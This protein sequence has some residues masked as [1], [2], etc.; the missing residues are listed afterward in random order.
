MATTPQDRLAK[1]FAGQPLPTTTPSGDSHFSEIELQEKRS[2]DQQQPRWQL[3]STAEYPRQV[4]RSAKPQPTSE[5]LTSSDDDDD[6]VSSFSKKPSMKAP[7][8]QSSQSKRC[9]IPEPNALG[10]PKD[11]PHEGKQTSM[12]LSQDASI[13]LHNGKERDIQSS[14]SAP[15]PLTGRF[16]QFILASKFPYKYMKD[17]NDRVSRHFFAN[18]KFYSRNWDL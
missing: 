9:V 8:E 10:Y 11:V 13:K 3:P 7:S 2:K 14:N 1:L 5:L 17:A 4:T 16:C 18:N 15:S 6:Y 12:Q